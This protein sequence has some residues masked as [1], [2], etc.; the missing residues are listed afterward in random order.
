MLIDRQH[1]TSTDVT[2]FDDVHS[3]DREHAAEGGVHE[4]EEEREHCHGLLRGFD[5]GGLVGQLAALSEDGEDDEHLLRHH[6]DNTQ[7]K[8]N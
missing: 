4:E 8:P 2:F 5:R 1:N 3:E 6:E 7:Q